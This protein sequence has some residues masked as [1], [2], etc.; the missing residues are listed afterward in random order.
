MTPIDEVKEYE[1][2]QYSRA[3]PGELEHQPTHAY[4]HVTNAC[5]AAM[6]RDQ[7]PKVGGGW[8]GGGGAVEWSFDARCQFLWSGDSEGNP[9]GYCLIY[10]TGISIGAYTSGLSP[11]ARHRQELVVRYV[12]DILCRLVAHEATPIS[13]THFSVTRAGGGGELTHS[14]PP[15]NFDVYPILGQWVI[16]RKWDS[17]CIRRL[18]ANHSPLASFPSAQA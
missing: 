15:D 12:G 8:M 11:A 13:H 4:A 1:V 6:P 17:M 3:G 18:G 5:H 2:E 16:A 14:G 10:S 7:G 9:S